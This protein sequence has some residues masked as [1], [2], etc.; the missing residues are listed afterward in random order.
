MAKASAS[1]NATPDF[2]ASHDEP[3]RGGRR[4]AWI[5]A[6]SVQRGRLPRTVERLGA[7]DDRIDRARTDA[8]RGDETMTTETQRNRR[9]CSGGGRAGSVSRGSS[10]KDRGESR[11]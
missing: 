11:I 5:E 1:R 9:T 3:G 8:A 2:A 10:A 7:P 6:G 4:C